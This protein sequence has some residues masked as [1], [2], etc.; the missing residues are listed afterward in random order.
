VPGVDLLLQVV[1]LGQ[2]RLVLGGEVIEDAFQLGPEVFRV[3]AGTRRNLIDYQIMEL[4]G[5]FQATLL[6]T[7]GHGAPTLLVE[8]ILVNRD[9]RGKPGNRSA[10]ARHRV[11]YRES[12]GKRFKA[13][14]DG[15]PEI[16]RRHFTG[17]GAVNHV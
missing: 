9:V 10:S 13:R 2:Q 1:A 16:R 8:R 11:D 15:H 14:K 7:I 4:G 12:P 5:D 3:D 17:N 6:N